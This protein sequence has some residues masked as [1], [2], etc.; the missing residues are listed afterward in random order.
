MRN[1]GLAMEM[2]TKSNFSNINLDFCKFC[3]TEK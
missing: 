3:E 2:E 1:E